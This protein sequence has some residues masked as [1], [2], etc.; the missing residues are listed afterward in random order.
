M[1]IDCGS[2]I[3]HDILSAVS[4]LEADSVLRLVNCDLKSVSYLSSQLPLLR[5]QKWDAD[6]QYKVASNVK[7]NQAGE[8]IE[9]VLGSV[10]FKIPHSYELENLALAGNLLG[11]LALKD[12]RGFRAEIAKISKEVFG[13]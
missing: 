4:L 11:E 6:K 5:D 8:H 7:S 1:I 9:Q 13:I 2:Q 3:A 10:A 12:S